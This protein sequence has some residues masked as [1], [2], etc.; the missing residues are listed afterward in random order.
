MICTNYIFHTGYF[1][2]KTHHGDKNMVIFAPRWMFKAASYRRRRASMWQIQHRSLVASVYRKQHLQGRCFYSTSPPVTYA[3]ITIKTVDSLWKT[4][5][6]KSRMPANVRRAALGRRS[7]FLINSWNSRVDVGIKTTY[8]RRWRRADKPVFWRPRHCLCLVCVSN[9]GEEFC[10]STREL[11]PPLLMWHALR[12][13]RGWLA[14]YEHEQKVRLT[15]A[16]LA[17]RADI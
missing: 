5:A 9:A 3:H 14:W 17:S 13:W 16:S 6:Q 2:S 7:F 10:F 11:S 8:V 12:R 15:R 1:V 4:A